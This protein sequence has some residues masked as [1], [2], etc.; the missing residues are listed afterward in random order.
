MN[1]STIGVGIDLQ[2]RS[3]RDMEYLKNFSCNRS[4]S[5]NQMKPNKNEVIGIGVSSAE[6]SQRDKQMMS[7]F[8]CSRENFTVKADKIYPRSPRDMDMLNNFDSPC[9]EK[10]Q[11]QGSHFNQRAKISRLNEK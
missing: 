7:D 10:F 2:P 8:S 3:S 4:N 11:Y 1:N 5:S 6:R 9:K